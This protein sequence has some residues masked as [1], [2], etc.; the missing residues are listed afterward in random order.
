[1]LHTVLGTQSTSNWTLQS[2][3]KGANGSLAEETVRISQLSPSH[4][5]QQAPNELLH[6][7]NAVDRE[8]LIR[9]CACACAHVQLHGG[10][11]A[12][13]PHHARHVLLLHVPFNAFLSPRLPVK[14]HC[15]GHLCT[16]PADTWKSQQGQV[17]SWCSEPRVG[18][19]I[20][21][22]SLCFAH[23]FTLSRN[24]CTNAVTGTSAD[25]DLLS[26]ER[27]RHKHPLPL[28][29][30][31]QECMHINETRVHNAI[32][33]KQHDSIHPRTRAPFS[34]SLIAHL[35]RRPQGCTSMRQVDAAT[36]LGQQQWQIRL[37][38]NSFRPSLNCLAA[39]MMLL[40]PTVSG[41]RK[42]F[43]AGWLSD[44]LS[45]SHPAVSET[46]TQAIP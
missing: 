33:Q 46:N 15:S 6:K 44:E 26:V 37:G 7:K 35:R 10:M 16:S 41:T 12:T 8:L 9:T 23:S 27:R 22:I 39:T 3:V 43:T 19:P 5:Q 24:L 4:H 25:L 40:A 34:K 28:H 18:E 36:L 30:S 14:G 21:L 31:P 45:D 32:Q 11:H 42:S 38:P 13:R 1:V 20:R 17:P 2:C 29:F